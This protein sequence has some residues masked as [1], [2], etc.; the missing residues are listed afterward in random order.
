[1]TSFVSLGSSLD[2]CGF[3]PLRR[4]NIRPSSHF[5][6]MERKPDLGVFHVS[7][8]VLSSISNF[9]RYSSRR[10]TWVSKFSQNFWTLLFHVEL[11]IWDGLTLPTKL[12]KFFAVEDTIAPSCRLVDDYTRMQPGVP[13]RSASCLS[14][15]F[16]QSALVTRRLRLVEQ[17]PS[18][19]L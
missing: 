10:L 2:L 1:M 7:L 8:R 9:I 11:V 19:T 13:L 6:V 18:E 5:R 14:I 17:A 15:S 16:K 3:A 12:I 4:V